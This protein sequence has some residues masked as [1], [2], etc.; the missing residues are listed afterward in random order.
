MGACTPSA[1][2]RCSFSYRTEQWRK[3]RPRVVTGYIFHITNPPLFEDKKKKKKLC[4]S[5]Y[6]K[7]DPF[8][9]ARRLP[10]IDSNCQCRCWLLKA[11]YASWDLDGE[12]RALYPK[13]LIR[14]GLTDLEF[15]KVMKKSR[16]HT[17]FDQK[18]SASSSNAQELA[19]GSVEDDIAYSRRTVTFPV[20]FSRHVYSVLWD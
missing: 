5:P 1:I 2:Q 12:L 18:Q 4:N 16:L 19:G 20:T 17:Q 8:L 6:H 3:H 15:Y 11:R 14:N 9:M 7:A 10:T 13:G